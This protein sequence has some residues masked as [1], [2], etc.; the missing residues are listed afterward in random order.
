[1]AVSNFAAAQDASYEQNALRYYDS[2]GNIKIVRGISDS[3]VGSIGTFRRGNLSELVSSSANALKEAK[4][5][6]SNYRKGAWV[7]AA[8]VLVLGAWIGTTQVDQMNPGVRTTLLLGGFVALAVG[9]TRLEAAYQALSKA[10]WWYNR[11]LSK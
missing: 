8:G 2:Q 9:A 1:M 7:A 10:I 4:V 3:V 11:D 6:E 5:F